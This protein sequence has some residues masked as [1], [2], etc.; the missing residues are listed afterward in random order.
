MS[1]PLIDMWKEYGVRLEK[2]DASGEKPIYFVSVPS[3][4]EFF[5][6][7]GNELCGMLLAKRVKRNLGDTAE[8][9]C[10]VRPERWTPA[11]AANV[12]CQPP[13][14]NVDDFVRA[15][16]A[17]NERRKQEN[18][19]AFFEGLFGDGFGGRYGR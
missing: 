13:K 3:M 11:K 5:D 8:V 6:D 12:D 14:P 10:R 7:K 17:A 18:Y 19:R 4:S 1:V 2:A 15:A 9:R 16:Y